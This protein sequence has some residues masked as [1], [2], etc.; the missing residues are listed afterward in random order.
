MNNVTMAQ[1]QSQT[2]LPLNYETDV[3]VDSLRTM[4][5]V[6]RAELAYNRITRWGAQENLT[7]SEWENRCKSEFERMM[8]ETLVSCAMRLEQDL[9][10]TLKTENAHLIGK[11]TGN[12]LRMADPLTIVASIDI[13]EDHSIDFHDSGTV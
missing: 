6:Q 2:P 10:E 7:L 9:P 4:T 13:E 1:H 8:V 5:I 11:A 3:D 12:F